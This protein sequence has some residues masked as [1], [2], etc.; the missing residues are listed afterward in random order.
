MYTH[1]GSSI[2]LAVQALVYTGANAATH[3]AESNHGE[4]EEDQQ[5]GDVLNNCCVSRKMTT[6]SISWQ[7]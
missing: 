7:G 2:S 5:P 4:A 6:L 3:Q 1:V